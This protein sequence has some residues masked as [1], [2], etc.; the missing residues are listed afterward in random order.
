MTLS[1]TSHGQSIQQTS[2]PSH[3]L[4]N[5][6]A[7]LKAGLPT[8]NHTLRTQDRTI[9][10]WKDKRQGYH[11]N[12]LVDR[13]DGLSS[14]TINFNPLG[15]IQS[16]SENGDPMELSDAMMESMYAFTRLAV[17]NPVIKATCRVK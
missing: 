10:A 11:L 5:H 6:L 2:P 3:Y 16:A 17:D 13:G 14:L 9:S 1:R 8:V 15:A 7:M 12:S 4:C